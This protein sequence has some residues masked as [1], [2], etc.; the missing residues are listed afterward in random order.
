MGTVI[1]QAFDV[2]V[3]FCFCCVKNGIFGAY[4]VRQ[5]GWHCIPCREMA[6]KNMCPPVLHVHF[7][8]ARGYLPQTEAFSHCSRTSTG[9]HKAQIANSIIYDG[10]RDY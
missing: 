6:T 2:F 5:D 7:V 3:A 1:S 4:A 9:P 8:T 10:K